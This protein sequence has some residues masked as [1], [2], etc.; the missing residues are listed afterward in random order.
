MFRQVIEQ[1]LPKSQT[2]KLRAHIHALELPI[3]LAKELDTAA[4]GGS[5]VIAQHEKSDALRDQFFDTISVTTFGWV[6]W[7]KMRFKLRNQSDGVR[8]IGAF[9]RDDAWHGTA[10]SS[11]VSRFHL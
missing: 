11:L 10:G 7:S 2:T 4:A 5:I 9:G 8:A 1:Q 6:E 3:D